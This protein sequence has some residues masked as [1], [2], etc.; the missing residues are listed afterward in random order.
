MKT[1]PKIGQNIKYDMLMLSNY[2]IEVKGK[3]YDTMLAHYLIQP[4][5]NTTSIFV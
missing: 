1:L 4:D 2:G 3:L 5:L